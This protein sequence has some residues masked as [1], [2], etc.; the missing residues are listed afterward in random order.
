MDEETNK[1]YVVMDDGK[2][3]LSEALKWGDPELIFR[4]NLYP[5]MVETR[6]VKAMRHALSVL[7]KFD[8]EKDYLLLVGDQALTAIAMMALTI[9][10]NNRVRLLKFDRRTMDYYVIDLNFK[11]LSNL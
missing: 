11:N 3:D 5:D 2:R 9:L 7:S 10:G 6:A 8:E 4:F 1:V